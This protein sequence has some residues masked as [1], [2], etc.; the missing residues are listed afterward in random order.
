MSPEQAAEY[1]RMRG[2]YLGLMASLE[3]NLTWLLTEWLDV[4]N[5]REE[6]R[7]WFSEAPIPLRS[8][9]RL[10]EA[11]TENS[12]MTE[13]FGDLPGQIRECYDFRNTLA[14]SFV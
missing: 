11:V 12:L 2:E 3:L 7:R 10:Y 8:K 14:H 5:H 13:Q 4:G 1:N 9:L 6:F